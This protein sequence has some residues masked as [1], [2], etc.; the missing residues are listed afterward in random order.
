M[1]LRQHVPRS[2]MDKTTCRYGM[3]IGNNIILTGNIAE[4][5]LGQLPGT[6]ETVKRSYK[7]VYV[8]NELLIRSQE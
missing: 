4:V 5:K 7:Y 3:L 1:K 6:P 2:I 8:K